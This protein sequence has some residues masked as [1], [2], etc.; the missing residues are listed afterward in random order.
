MRLAPILAVGAAF[1]FVLASASTSA[2]A[3]VRVVKFGKS[4]NWNVR[5]VFGSTGPFD[6]CSAN[7]RYRSGTRVS[8]IV[9]RSGSWRLWFVNDTWP[10][11][12]T[13]TFPAR[14]EV[15]GRVVLSQNGRYK[16][17]NAYINLGS[18]VDRV[19]ALMRGRA[20]SIV[21]PAGTSKFSL[22]GTN[23]AT[24][25]LARCWKANYKSGTSSGAFG[26][27]SSNSATGGAFGA[28]AVKRRTNKNELSRANTMEIAASYLSKSSQPY[29]ILPKDKAP[30]KHFPVNWKMQDGSIGGM[31]VFKNTNVKVDRL[32]GTLLSDQAKHC[33]GRNASQREAAK[34]IRG[35]QTMRAR[36]V[37]ETTSGK[38]LNIT[39]KVAEIG[40]RMVMM[41][42]ELRSASA[43]VAG[44]KGAKK[45]EQG[46]PKAG[47]G[48]IHVPGP[49]EL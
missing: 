4:G 19:K 15:D 33:T 24:Q 11:R 20:M 25:L 16:G 43:P 32:L 18:R 39:Y 46:N 49:N 42:M 5:A 29:S 28:P 12:G 36:G 23:R 38:V 45:S 10:D 40:Q 34:L 9:Y 3:K 44:S 22:K 13:A 21:T 35:R 26:S 6:H 27:A 48:G 8:I 17:R 2:D 1:G 7:A 30:L 31:R 47:A 14:L 37:C 41:V